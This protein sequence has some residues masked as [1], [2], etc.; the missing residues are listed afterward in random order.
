[1][2]TNDRKKIEKLNADLNDHYEFWFNFWYDSSDW[3]ED[4]PDGRENWYNW[5]I[6]LNRI[7]QEKL[8][9]IFDL[10]KKPTIEDIWPDRK[11]LK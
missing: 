1:M 8:E 5:S 3:Y 6:D 4:D 10:N 7:R 9:E 2:K 11:D